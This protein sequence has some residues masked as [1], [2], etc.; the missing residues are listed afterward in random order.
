MGRRFI[1]LECNVE[2]Y[3]CTRSCHAISRK[4]LAEH[5]PRTQNVSGLSPAYSISRQIQGLPPTPSL[6]IHICSN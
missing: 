5:M 6:L 2:H 4:L 1:S 3:I